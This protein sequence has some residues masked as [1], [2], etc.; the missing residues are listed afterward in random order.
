VYRDTDAQ[1][2]KMMLPEPND[3]IAGAVRQINAHL[4]A[5]SARFVSRRALLELVMLG[6]IAREHVLLIGP[7][8]TG[9][10]AAVQAIAETIDATSF[11][12]LIG[13]F[14]EPSELFGALDLNA[15]KDGRIQPVTHGMLP[16]AEVAFLDEI[17]LGST[18][19]LN[20]LL[21][22]LNERTY[23]R[24]QYSVQVPLISCVAASNAM[25]EDTLLAAFA[26]RFLLTMFVDP[27]G[28]NEL[29]ALLETGWREATQ[30]AAPVAPVGKQ[31]IAALHATALAVDMA[32]VHQ[33]YAHIVR[34]VRLIGVTLSDRKLVKAQK[35]IAAAALLRGSR[36]AGPEDLWPIT[37]LVQS[38]A[39]QEEVRELLHAE[40]QHSRNPV[41]TNSVAQATYGPTAHAAHLTEQATLLL[42][43]R[44]ALASDPLHEIWLVRLETMLTR[45]D[46]AFDAANLPQQLRV[47]RA[48]VESLLSANGGAGM[49]AVAPD[50][51]PAN[52]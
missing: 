12:Y 19:I 14:T 24:G 43:S 7:P 3:E 45:I 13:R 48:S 23:R 5:L 18:A 41:L 52:G 17:F 16:E 10:S 11:E 44:P 31:V 8:G 36:E 32:P 9:K 49:T 21:K 6:L 26:D 42:E 4:D 28:E 46:A 25:P 39:Q 51:V 33:A 34:K 35:L 40:L 20:S 2:E 29:A 1:N 22:I 37:Y 47:V 38:K 15:L 50:R 30:G 27:V